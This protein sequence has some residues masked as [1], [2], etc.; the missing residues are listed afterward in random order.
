MSNMVEIV[1][2]ATN[3]ASSVLNSVNDSLGSLGEAGKVAGGVAVGALAGI[4][5]AMAVVAGAGAKY[6]AMIESSGSRWETLTGSIEGANKQMDFISGYAKSSP[7][8]YQGIDET[9]TS[10]MGMGMELQDVNKWIPTLGDMASVMGGGTETIKGVGVALGQMSAK[11]KV[12]AEEMGQLA[13]RGVNGWQMIADAMGLSV[14]E[15]RKLSE[16]GKLLA[17]DALPMIQAGMAKTFGGGTATYMQS[18]AGQF[19]QLKEGAS[20]FA[21]QLTQGAYEY[22]GSTV[23]PF[24]NSGLTGLATVFS[25]GLVDGFTK[26]ATESGKGQIAI[27]LM[28]G[29][30]TALLIPALI[31]TVSALAPVVVAFL[32]F[33]AIGAVVAGVVY[34]IMTNWSKL[35]PM[36]Y[37]VF[38]VIKPMVEGFKVSFMS[39][40]QALLAGLSP[41]W[42]AMKRLFVSVKPILIAVG[43]A[44]GI[45]LSVAMAVFNGVIQAIAPVI[46][47]FLSLVDFV[48]NVVMAIVSVLAGDWSGAMASWNRATESAVNFFKSIWQAI[49]GFF[50]GFVGTFVSILSNFGVDVVGG[51]NKMWSSAQSAVSAGVAKVI[52]FFINLKSKATSSVKELG[53][54]IS[55]G[56]KN[57]M[58][59]AQSAVSSGVA[60]VITFF[61]NLKSKAISSISSLASK[62]VSSFSSMMSNGASAVSSGVSR[63]VGAIKGFAGTFLSAGKGLLSAFTD[64]IKSGIS[65]AVGAVKNGMAK[66]RDF[67]PFSPA[68]KGALSDLDKS[69]ESFFPTWYEGALKQVPAMTRAVGGAM[70]SLNSEMQGKNGSVALEAFTGG[71]NRQTLTIQIEGDVSVKGDSGREQVKFV[72]EEIQTQV[73]SG[74]M[75]DLRQVIRKR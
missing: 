45:F 37:S 31:A 33:I 29:A 41:I 68:K 22:F 62:L 25:G 28:A 23:L 6:N 35:A 21:G 69:G 5:G 15:V 44:L 9:A 52:S 11:G 56:F 39:S 26:M 46:T 54:S 47:A 74:V 70:S 55:N 58:S 61:S 17:K 57:A 48:V 66:I 24:L 10:L 8:D 13:E 75:R 36:F 64:G 27:A 42:E 49:V 60:K 30:L 51:F 40:I 18:T 53:S 34:L 38:S 12:S 20:Q 73:E 1:I 59:Q 50:K 2:N 65:N 72:S 14:G 32:P 4:A 16:D 71:N 63:I 7:F 43:I 67:L 19:D 3:N